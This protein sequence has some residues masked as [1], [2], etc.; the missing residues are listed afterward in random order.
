[1]TVS[2][3]MDGWFFKS[4]Q[5][6]VVVSMSLD[7]AQELLGKEG[8]LSNILVSNL[9]DQESGVDLTESVVGEARGLACPGG[10][11]AGA[12]RHKAVGHRF[13]QRMGEPVPELL[14]RVSGSFP[15]AS[16]CCLFS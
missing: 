5:Y 6:E 16:A 7:R 11:R 1:M 4:E 12:P 8:R 15:L 9:G 13:R 14:H 3:I 2:A 10:Q